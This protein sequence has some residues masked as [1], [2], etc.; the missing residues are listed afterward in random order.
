M[1]GH[2]A[3]IDG[4]EVKKIS[5]LHREKKMRLVKGVWD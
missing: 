4:R 2:M 1:W 5:S 3:G